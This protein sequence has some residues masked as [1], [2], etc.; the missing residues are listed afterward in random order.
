VVSKAGY[1]PRAA[2]HGIKRDGIDE[3]IL[4]HCL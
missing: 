2:G 1:F 4:I 3:H